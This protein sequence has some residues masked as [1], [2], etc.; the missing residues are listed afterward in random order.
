MSELRVG[1]IGLGRMGGNHFNVWSR[2]DGVRVV[3]IAEPDAQRFHEV[4]GPAAGDVARHDT[5]DQLLARGD[6]D[7]VSIVLPS[8][9]HAE[10]AIAAA[11]AGVHAL[12]EKPLA[13][14]VPEAM[15]MAKAADE[16]GKLLTV[17]HVERFNP[18]AASCASSSPTAPLGGCS[19]C[20]PRAWARCRPASWMRA[21]RSISP[22]TTSISWS[23]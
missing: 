20:M 16:A 6:V 8:S 12:V 19:A 21:S 4:V 5:W 14:T 23:G 2:L 11:R 18:A 1:I 10:A 13:T 17:G 9:L 15:A 7:A 3:A 22:R